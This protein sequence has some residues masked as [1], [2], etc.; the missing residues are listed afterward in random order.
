[1]GCYKSTRSFDLFF[2]IFAQF[3]H[4]S[5]YAPQSTEEIINQGWNHALTKDSETIIFLAFEYDPLSVA[6]FDSP[7]VVLVE[8][9][10]LSERQLLVTAPI[11][12]A[13]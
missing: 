6:G 11:G 12:K 5:W 3:S 13:G 10:S 1:M 8:A 4:L 7:V 2:E 9:G